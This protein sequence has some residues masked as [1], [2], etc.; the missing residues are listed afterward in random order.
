[1]GAETLA[2]N[3]A[4]KPDIADQNVCCQI[5]GFERG[6]HAE[7]HTV[8]VAFSFIKG[9]IN[10]MLNPVLY[11]DRNGVILGVNKSFSRQI[12]GL[13]EEKI[14]GHT[15]TAVARSTSEKLPG[16]LSENEQQSILSCFEEWDKTDRQRLKSGES[17]TLE[18]KG[19]C[20]DQVK[21]SFLVNKSAFS[22]ERGE[23]HG[24]V[25]VMQD[26]T[27]IR[28]TEENLRKDLE[29]KKKLLDE[30]PVPV[31]YKNTEGRYTGCNKLFTKE[32]IGLPEE[33]IT[34]RVYGELTYQAPEDLIKKYNEADVQVYRDGIEHCCELKSRYLPNCLGKEFIVIKAPCF[35]ED[36]KINGLVGAVLDVT[37]RNKAQRELQESEE[38]YRSF[39][40][41][42]KGIVFQADENFVPVFL[43]GTVEEITGYSEEEFMSEQ[44]WKNIIHPEDLPRMYEE[45][46]RIQNSPG[47][48]YGEIDFRIM[49]RKGITKWVHEIYQKIPGCNGKP[50]MY[51]GAIYDI[52]E[53]K[54]AEESLATLELARK[55]EIHHRIKNNLQVISSLLDLQAERFRNRKAVKTS[56]VLEAFLESQN[57]VVSMALIHEELH[58]GGQVDTLNFSKYLQ[59]L[60]ENLFETNRIGNSDISLN[61]DLEENI[62]FD[63]DTAVPLGIIVNELVSNSFKHAFSGREKGNIQIKLYREETR[64]WKNYSGEDEKE[65]YKNTGFMLAVKDNGKGIPENLD[66]LNPETLG[67]QLVTTLVD[68]LGGKLELKRARGTEFRIMFATTE[69]Q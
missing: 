41:N 7:T 35:S 42:F 49:H 33:E 9:I 5:P 36:E 52:T 32:I 69:K 4:K 56:E 60:T 55:K 48:G 61:M 31:F 15:L 2:D 17:L 46:K 63:M 64:E 34:G 21:R 44:P 59:K 65:D 23:I 29:F 11:T 45:E 53:R 54:E 37:E 39:I 57:R 43:H 18:C 13:P 14:I 50:D 67:L 30:I 38:K 66:I 40:K 26:I 20:A 47:A 8:G 62:F 12:A 16:K 68:Q 51:Q 19:I 58:K 3:E 28:Q 1:L 27:E 6:E 25:T 22:D 10:T 24:L